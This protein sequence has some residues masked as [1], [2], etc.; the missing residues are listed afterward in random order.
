MNTALHCPVA[1]ELFWIDLQWFAAEDEGRTEDPTDYKLRK[2]REEG[3]VAKSQDINAALVLLFPAGALIVLSSFFLENCM[4][5]L[6]F[7]FLRSTQ[8]DIRSGVWFGIFVQ[9][10]LQLALP[11]ALIALIAGVTANIIQNNGFI[12]STKPIQPQFN[13]INPDFMRFFKRALFSA[14]GLFNFAKSLTKVIALV[15]IAFLMIRANI[16]HFIELLSVS[17]PQA[18]FFI[19]GAAAKLLAAAALL[20]LIFAIPDYFFQRKQFIDSLKMSKQ[21][22]KEEYK[23]LEG[24]PQVKGRIRQQMQAILSQNAI[25]NVPKADVVITNPTHYAIAMQWD[26]KTMA[27]PMVLAKGADAMALKIKEIA[28]EHNIPLIENKPL[29]RAL[30]AKVEI[31]DIIPE[32]YYRALSLVFAEVYTLNN[33][34]QEFYR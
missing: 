14:E 22:I 33:K 9:Y 7:F 34:K 5:I 27:A 11:L 17:L 20:L 3:R 2:A 10:F 31:G 6:R 29:A 13:R 16:P 8:A 23:E 19:A 18:V 26:S 28:R 1:E 21:E 24:D 25:R 12:F 32:E 30:Y 4:E 15:F